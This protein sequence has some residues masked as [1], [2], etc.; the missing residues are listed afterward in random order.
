MDDLIFIHDPA[1][2]SAVRR[3]T[4][5]NHYK[6]ASSANDDIKLDDINDLVNNIEHNDDDHD[7]VVDNNYV[8]NHEFDDNQHNHNGSYWLL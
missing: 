4:D 3:R 2:R 7:A 8:N 1:L 5:I 6:H